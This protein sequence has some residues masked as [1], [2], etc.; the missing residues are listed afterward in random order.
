MHSTTW[1]FAGR[2]I[3]ATTLSTVII[4]GCVGCTPSP[5]P[6]TPSGLTAS[7]VNEKA[8]NEQD[9]DAQLQLCVAYQAQPK[10]VANA[11]YQGVTDI[12][13]ETLALV[14]SMLNSKCSR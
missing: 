2:L 5:E 3:A 4:T 13:G 9:V 10:V 11:M 12:T 6:K 7:Q 8:W 14:T 1:A